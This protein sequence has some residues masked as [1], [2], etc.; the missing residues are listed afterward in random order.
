MAETQKQMMA[1]AEQVKSPESGHDWRTEPWVDLSASSLAVYIGMHL[2]LAI[3][4][5]A[6]AGATEQEKE[7][8]MVLAILRP[9]IT[10]RVLMR[11]DGH[12]YIR[13]RV[14]Q[15]IAQAVEICTVA[16]ASKQVAAIAKTGG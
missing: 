6:D 13:H 8:A 4:T 1:T 12:E 9:D 15:A 5:D 14:A 3:R 11:P 16:F 2:A 10:E 7:D